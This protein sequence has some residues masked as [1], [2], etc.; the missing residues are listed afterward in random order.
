MIIAKK[1]YYMTSEEVSKLNWKRMTREFNESIIDAYIDMQNNTHDKIT[2]CDMIL[3]ALKNDSHKHIREAEIESKLL[4]IRKMIQNGVYSPYRE[5]DRLIKENNA[6]DKQ[7]TEL[8]AQLELAR[9]E[10]DEQKE[11]DLVTKIV[12]QSVKLGIEVAKNVELVLGRIY[13]GTTK[14]AEH[15]QWLED[16]IAETVTSKDILNAIAE[17]NK[18]LKKGVEDGVTV[19]NT[20]NYNKE[21]K[22]QTN[23]YSSIPPGEQVHN[24]LENEQR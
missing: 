23:S 12:E 8:M 14:F 6:K 7:I 21:V 2:V 19:I 16:Y 20:Q 5:I 15:F 13:R 3:A 4:L 18:T 22:Q 17:L 24:L 9:D 10:G 11:T 1:L